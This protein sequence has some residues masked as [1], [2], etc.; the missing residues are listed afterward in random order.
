MPYL[1]PKLGPGM[2][3]T[4]EPVLLMF[5]WPQLYG[6]VG[7]GLIKLA[8]DGLNSRVGAILG[9]SLAF[10]LPRILTASIPPQLTA[11]MTKEWAP[12]AA[13]ALVYNTL[14]ALTHSLTNSISHH[15]SQAVVQGVTHSI[16]HG[17]IHYYYCIYCYTM[18][19]YCHYCQSYNKFQ[20]L[21]RQVGGLGRYAQTESSTV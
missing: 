1:S 19:D 15:L 5:L 13:K 17:L 16:T 6:P 4:A 18:G 10:H 8:T 2:V 7:Q 14:H 12:Q 11:Y 3:A 21:G 9:R 20:R